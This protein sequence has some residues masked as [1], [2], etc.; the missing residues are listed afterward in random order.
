MMKSPLIKSQKATDHD[1]LRLLPTRAAGVCARHREPDSLVGTVSSRSRSLQDDHV[2]GSIL[3]QLKPRLRAKAAAR[4][5]PPCP[6][7]D[8]STARSRR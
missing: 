2:D 4:P 7:A 3:G 8:T 5:S 1:L 6:W